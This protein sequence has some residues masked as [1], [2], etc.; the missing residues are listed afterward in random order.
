MKT[1]RNKENAP[2]EK[3]RGILLLVL[4]SFFVFMN[5]VKADNGKKIYDNNCLVCHGENLHGDMPGVP[6]L[7]INR[8][9]T[10]NLDAQI[11]KFV[12]E[13]TE[14]SGKAIVMPSKGGNPNLSDEQI[15]SAIMYMRDILKRS[16]PQ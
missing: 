16:S 3:T 14:N 12:T 7:I 10:M 13:G 15:K 4:C 9:W 6:D 2:L 5:S 1:Y 8:A 11:H